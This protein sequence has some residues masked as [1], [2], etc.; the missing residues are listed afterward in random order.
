MQVSSSV[1]SY[2]YDDE[3]RVA[4]PNFYG[5]ESHTSK[6]T[7]TTCESGT[8]SCFYNILPR[9][10]SDSM[11]GKAESGSQHLAHSL[12]QHGHTASFSSITMYYYG[13]RFYSPGIER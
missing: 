2:A 13:H 12:N 11:A 4:R 3:G 7:G 9:P 5:Y 10:L 6:P 1:T 8:A